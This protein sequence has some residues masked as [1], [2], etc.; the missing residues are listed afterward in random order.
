M[1]SRSGWWPNDGAWR[2]GFSPEEIIEALAA[3][4]AKNEAREWPGWR[5]EEQGKAI[6]HIK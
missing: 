2:Q 1:F 4:Q 3:K 6:E 5:T